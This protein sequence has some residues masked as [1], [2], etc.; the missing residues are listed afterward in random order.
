M[1]LWT[2]HLL[3]SNRLSREIYRWS[4]DSDDANVSQKTMTS[5][6]HHDWYSS[7]SA[8]LWS[9]VHTI[10]RPSQ[11]NVQLPTVRHAPLSTLQKETIL[12]G[13]WNSPCINSQPRVRL[14]CQ[15]RSRFM[16]VN[17][18]YVFGR[19]IRRFAKFNVNKVNILYRIIFILVASCSFR[20][21]HFHYIENTRHTIQLNSEQWATTETWR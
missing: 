17:S 4:P 2:L 12:I 1:T 13:Y 11:L 16:F 5:Y 19:R 10:H 7:N 3:W 20:Y 18:C 6:L 8:L 9:K 14:D 21:V 15:K